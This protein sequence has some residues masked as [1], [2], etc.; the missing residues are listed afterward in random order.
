MFRVN[1]DLSIYVTRGDIVALSISAQSDGDAYTFKTGDVVR[2]KVFEKKGCDCVMMQKDFTVASDSAS[3]D[4]SLTEKDT[5]IGGVISKPRDYWYE[6]ELN[7]ETN[8]QTIIGYD[9]DGAKV[10]RLFP[11]GKEV[12]ELEPRDIPFLDGELDAESKNPV[13]NRAIAEKFAEVDYA[14]EC[15]VTSEA[16][17]HNVTASQVGAR[18]DTWMPS[19]SDVGARPANWMPTADDVGAKPA[20]W[21]PTLDEI[22]AVPVTRTVNGK[23]L[24]G[25]IVLTAADVGAQGMELPTPEEIGAV[26]EEAFSV[27][28]T[29]ISNLKSDV[30]ELYDHARSDG[31]P[32]K[33]TASQVGARPDTWM[34]TAQEVGARPDTWMPTAAQVGARPADWMPSAAD[35]GARPNTWVP[36]ASEVGARANT[37]LPTIAEIGA[38]PAGYGLGGA[39]TKQ[40][41]LDQLDNTF[42]SGWYLLAAQ[43][44]TINGVYFNYACVFVHGMGN[45]TCVQEIRPFAQNAVLRRYAYNSAWNEWEC[46][47]P[48]MNLGVEYRT[49]ERWNGKPV[50]TTLV[51]VGNLP[52]KNTASVSHG[53]G[54][55]TAI[56]SI[57]TIDDAS[58]IP[59][60]AWGST[61]DVTVTPNSIVLTTNYDASA[62]K[63]KVQMWYTKD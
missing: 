50:Y 31:N 30:N 29:D 26:S 34:P 10:F 38:A 41:A 35:V 8:P 27:A 16:N 14:V 45:G 15:H 22:G 55:K 60:S 7:P 6:V 46:E 9:E 5:R 4:I 53:F 20:D 11:E 13:Q 58:T 54:V 19:A 43:G 1:D 44:T 56:R 28:Q 40:L 37:W 47:N 12:E 36:S 18:P 52:N 23:P 62:S 51:S 57:G 61:V 59:Y 39:P 17:P 21:M 3:V 24:D 25:D 2:F 32:H 33:V 49:T 63:A 42:A 48:P